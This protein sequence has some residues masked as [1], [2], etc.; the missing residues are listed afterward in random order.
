M[1]RVSS[2][3]EGFARP[4]AA[5]VGVAGGLALV[6]F[7]MP[8]RLVASPD[9]INAGWGPGGFAGRCFVIRP[10]SSTPATPP[11]YLSARRVLDGTAALS[12]FPHRR[13][14]GD[15]DQ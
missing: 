10:T 8:A 2:S 3:A 12:F 7:F 6:P 9:S 13:G 14:N 5:M 15:P 1:T 11:L 4:G